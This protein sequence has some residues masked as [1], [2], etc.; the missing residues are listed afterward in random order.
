V[1]TIT[2]G[3]TV[4][5]SDATT[6]SAA[7]VSLTSASVVITAGATGK[8]LLYFKGSSKNNTID[9]TS[10]M[11]YSVDGGAD[12]PILYVDVNATTANRAANVSFQTIVTGLSAA[13]HT[14]QIRWKVSGGTGTILGGTYGYEVGAIAL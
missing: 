12:I 10:V 14:F 13:S 6:A 9:Q 7:F 3:T 1:V 2:S 8:V 4:V 5:S 11:A